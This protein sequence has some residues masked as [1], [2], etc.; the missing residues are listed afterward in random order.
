M[1]YIKK[2]TKK[3]NTTHLGILKENHS[4]RLLRQDALGLL[5]QG[6]RLTLD[7]DNSRIEKGYLQSMTI[8]IYKDF[9]SESMKSSYNSTIKR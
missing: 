7:K 6:G 9:S 5:T 1:F 8:Q 4:Y 3:G 2:T